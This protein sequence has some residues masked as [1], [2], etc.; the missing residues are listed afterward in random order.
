MDYSKI[1]VA[2][3]GRQHSF[4]VAE[5]LE[6]NGILYRYATTVYDKDTS[7]A[8]RIVKHVL[9][10]NNLRRANNRKMVL[11]PDEKVIQFCEWEGLLLLLVQRFDH[12]RRLAVWMNDHISARFQKK[13]A[14]YIIRNDVGVVI[15]YDTNSSVLFDVLRKKAPSVIRIIDDAAPNR[16]YLCEIFKK[17]SEESGEFKKTYESF[18]YLSDSKYAERFGEESRKA[19]L[20]IVPSSFSMQSLAYNGIERDRVILAPYGVNQTFFKPLEKDYSSSLKILYVGEID[21]RKGVAQILQAAKRLH[22]EKIEFK[23][24]GPI[25]ENYSN[26]FIPYRPYVQFLGR[27]DFEELYELYGRSHIF[28]F[29]SMADSFGLVLLEALASGLPVIASRNCAGPDVVTEGYNGFLIDAGNTEQLVE[30]ILWFYHH[31][32]QLPQM[33]KNALDSVRGR[34]WSAYEQT[35]VSG[36]NEAIRNQIPIKRAQID[37]K[38]K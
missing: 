8:M 35:L 3:P 25:R 32:D 28:V 26:L 9:R 18:R 4:R 1:I 16:N 31:M 7:L 38:K 11:V 36:L 12:K 14:R 27:K 22:K 30:K 13:L 6:R 34:S 24:V 2:H 10:G 19:D 5:A 37:T 21:Q 20:H 17:L 23:L 33:Q 15:S 29:P